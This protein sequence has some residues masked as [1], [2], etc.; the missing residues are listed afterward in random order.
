MKIEIEIGIGIEIEMQKQMQMKIET[1][2]TTHE[3][4]VTSTVIEIDGCGGGG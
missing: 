4:L 3:V 1:G 2:R